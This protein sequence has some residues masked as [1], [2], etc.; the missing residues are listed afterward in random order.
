MGDPL[1]RKLIFAVLPVLIAVFIMIMGNGLLNTLIPYRATVEGFSPTTVGMIGSAYFIGMLA[2]TWTAAP[3]VRRVGHIR[4]FAAYS[5]VVSVAVLAFPLA[6]SPLPWVL[7]RALVGFCFAGLYAVVEGWISAKAGASHRG[8]MLGIYNIANFTGS[9]AGQQTLRLFE[10]KSFALFS[11]AASF[12]TLALVPMA[13]TRAEPPPIPAKGKLVIRELFRASLISFATAILLG[14]ANGTFWSI[15]PAYVQRLNLGPGTVASFMT[16]AI[17]GSALIPWP[18]GRLSDKF[19]RRLVIGG[20]SAAIM[21]TEIALW[22]F[23][24][25]S[26]ALLYTLGFFAGAFITA[27][28]PVAVSLSVDRLGP[29]KAVP[30]S[31]TTLFLYCIGAIIGPAFVASLMTHYGDRILFAHNAVIH[32]MMIGFVAWGVWR[33]GPAENHVKMTVEPPEAPL[34]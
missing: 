29:D 10:A 28:Y 24:K 12:L 20:L 9:M 15:I 11:A 27:I 31:S 33:E 13:M 19:D 34:N 2:G 17:L 14:L 7:L 26:P 30:V 23:A 8:R 16:A 22:Y 18:I 5:A 1:V 6:I 32:L 3:I 21:I 25:P 4:A